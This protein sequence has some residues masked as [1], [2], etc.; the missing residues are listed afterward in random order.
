MNFCSH[1]TK[2]LFSLCFDR[3]LTLLNPICFLSYTIVSWKFFNQRIQSEEVI[4]LNF[5]GKEYIEYQK[6]VPTGI[7]GINGYRVTERRTGDSQAKTQWS[8]KSLFIDHPC[9]TSSHVNSQIRFRFIFRF[10][11]PYCGDHLVARSDWSL[12]ETSSDLLCKKFL[13]RI[14]QDRSS[15]LKK[16]KR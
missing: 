7:L 9:R 13:T 1:P 3:Q 10:V 2:I 5:F 11:G 15:Y 16:Q 14:V 8:V 6:R 4:L 12:D